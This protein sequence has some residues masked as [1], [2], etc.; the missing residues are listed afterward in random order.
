[1]R[2][3]LLVLAISC[4]S[5][6]VSFAVVV[7]D[8]MGSHATTPGVPAFGVNVDGVVAIGWEDMTYGTGALITDRHI[9]A[10]AHIEAGNWSE[11]IITLRQM[12]IKESR[13]DAFDWFFLAIA[14]HKLNQ[15]EEAHRTYQKGVAWMKEHP[16][17]DRELP[18]LRDEAAKVL[19]IKE[20]TDKQ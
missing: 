16:F 5:P 12:P 11:V 7:S 3:L 19:D 14:Y 15:K 17:T 10:A 13:W 4:F 18:R 2:T 20:A 6:T 8:V 9:L 1:M